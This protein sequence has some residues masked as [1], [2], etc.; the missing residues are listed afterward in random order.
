MPVPVLMDIP[1]HNVE[2]VM[3]GF[4]HPEILKEL[5]AVT[6]GLKS[7]AEAE[8]KAGNRVNTLRATLSHRKTLNLDP[9]VIDDMIVE[10]QDGLWRMMYEVSQIVTH[11]KTAL[12]LVPNEMPSTS[13]PAIGKP[14][15]R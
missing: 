4:K 12:E 9:I 10:V 15:A 3:A 6:D 8:A 5:K 14:G 11:L 13:G 1:F 2:D 7:Y